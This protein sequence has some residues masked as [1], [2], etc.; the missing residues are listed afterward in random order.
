MDNDL[1]LLE[2][3][4]LRIATAETETA[5]ETLVNNLLCPVLMRLD[6][7]TPAVQ[8]KVSMQ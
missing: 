1:G 7:K 4:E 5:F 2:Q 6:S 3:V 8:Q